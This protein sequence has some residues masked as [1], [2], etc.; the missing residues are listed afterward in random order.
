VWKKFSRSNFWIKFKS[1][2]YWPFGIVQFPLFFYWLWLSLKARSLFFFSASNPEILMGGMMGESKFDVLKLV[3][4]EIKP[5]SILVQLPSS[6]SDVLATLDKHQL[7]FPVVFK[8]DLGERGWMVKIIRSDAD[9]ERYLSEIRIDFIIQELVDF[10]LEFG[11][12]YVR[13]PNEENGRVNSITMKD[14]LHVIGDGTS[15]L[16]EL[17]LT[18]DR[19]KLQWETLKVSYA[20]QLKHIPAKGVKIELVP[21]GNHCLGTTFLNGNHLITDQLNKSFDRISKQIK[22]FYFG[23]YDIRCAS[24]EDLERGKIKVLELNGCGAEPAHIYQPGF[25]LVAAFRVLF[26]HWRNLYVISAQNHSR[27]VP[28]L[29]FREGSAIFKRFKALRSIE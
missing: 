23:R 13:F 2:E 7:T 18:K 3:P 27:G 5:K 4:D 16:E 9:V 28:Y 11:V 6:L 14:F 10:P 17:I 19:A 20:D 25:S 8:P 1:W 29:S 21:I 26:T 22:G 12:F 24:F 15:T